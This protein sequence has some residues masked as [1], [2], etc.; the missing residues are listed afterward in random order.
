MLESQGEEEG[1][2]LLFRE[3]VPSKVFKSQ[4]FS[5]A[6]ANFTEPTL[7]EVAKQIENIAELSCWSDFSL[8]ENPWV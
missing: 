6:R 2:R 8:V 1:E 7:V 4:Y 3:L 5:E